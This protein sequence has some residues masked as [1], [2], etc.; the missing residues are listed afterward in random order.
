M[1][2]PFVVP[3]WFLLLIA[4]GYVLDVIL[5]HTRKRHVGEHW[6]LFTRHEHAMSHGLRHKRVNGKRHF[7][8]FWWH[9]NH[10]GGR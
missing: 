2:R 5:D 1:N 10:G 4:G 6:H 3:T 9:P 8:F 7:H